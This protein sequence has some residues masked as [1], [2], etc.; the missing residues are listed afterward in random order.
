M[1]N[2]NGHKAWTLNVPMKRENR[3]Y[4]DIVAS[5]T[6]FPVSMTNTE[7]TAKK[8][9]RFLIHMEEYSIQ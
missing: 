3:D 9:P 4:N 8:V 5:K 6:Q 1:F 7:G 2:V